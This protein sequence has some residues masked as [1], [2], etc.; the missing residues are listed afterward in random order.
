VPFTVGTLPAP[1]TYS[2]SYDTLGRLTSGPV[3]TYT[4]GDSAHLH[5]AT[6]IGSAYTASYDAAGNMTCRAPSS[7]TTCSGTQT[8]A[9][10]GYN[11]DGL[12]TTWQNAPTSP[13]STTANLYDGEGNRIEQQVT[14]SGTTTTTVY[15]GNLEQIATT[16]GT[17]TTTSYYYA[18]QT[19]IALAVNGTFSYLA[20]DALGSVS[21]AFNAV[22]T[23]TAASLYTPYGTT[24]YS[25]GTMPTDRGWTGQHSD[26]TTGLVYFGARYYDP[27]A[28][29]FTSADTYLPGNGSDALALSRYAYVEGNP[30]TRLDPTG[31]DWWSSLVSTVVQTATAV[32]AAAAPIVSAVASAASTVLDA[33][34][35]IPSMISDVQ[36]IFSGKASFLDKVLAA[37]DLVLNVTMDVTSVIGV[38]EGLRA[39]DVGAHIAEHVAADVGVHALEHAGED[40]T[41]HVLE[42]EGEDVAT[43]TA[44][45]EAE[46]TAEGAVESCG[47]PP[48][49]PP[50]PCLSGDWQNFYDAN[51]MGFAQVTVTHPD[52]STA[53]TQYQAG[54]GWGSADWVAPNVYNGQPLVEDTYQGAPTGTPLQDVQHTYLE[55]GNGNALCPVTSSSGQLYRNPYE[56]CFQEPASQT[57]YL[58]GDAQSSPAVPSVTETW[59]YNTSG[60]GENYYYLQVTSSTQTA[61]DLLADGVTAS[62]G[63]YGTTAPVFT[64][65]TSY[66]STIVAP[67]LTI[68]WI[69]PRR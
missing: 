37:G 44:E 39:A 16:G 46:H 53:V 4:Y 19:L 24:R 30:L 1:Y 63:S 62:G 67:G 61:N 11:S 68:W 57:T 13:T 51:F 12:L 18:G 2:F 38:G 26:A 35:G 43:H 3:G 47:V 41:A 9:Q 15:V 56:L 21:V 6:A 36:T 22:G 7:G 48:T 14:V 54:G 23:Q 33:T 27:V 45:E 50:N 28:A 10:M 20:A 29:Q 66:P 60:N 17:T 55:D 59:S 69:R 58:G 8:G 34:T 49:N 32:V 42:H 52:G 5:G 25:S 64:T 65:S 40:A 31:H